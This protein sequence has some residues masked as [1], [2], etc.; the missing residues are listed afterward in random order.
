M[1]VLADDLHAALLRALLHGRALPVRYVKRDITAVCLDTLTKLLRVR[2]GNDGEYLLRRL[3]G[4][5]E[6]LLRL[7]GVEPLA[8]GG[9]LFVVRLRL[10]QWYLMRVERALNEL[11]VEGLR[12]APALKT[13]S[14]NII[15]SNGVI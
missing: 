10:G 12:A 1:Q 3:S 7:V 11:A 2:L 5:G 4:L 14:V 15:A 6:E 8:K 13:R 9:E